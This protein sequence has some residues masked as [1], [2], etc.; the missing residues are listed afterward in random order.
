MD[1]T[2]AQQ[3]HPLADRYRLAVIYVFGSRAGEIAS[4][5][6][7]K[8]A[9]VVALQ[10]DVDVG[11]QPEKGERLSSEDRV[12]LTLALEDLFGARRVDLVVLPE[13]DAF[14]ALDIIRGE[15]LFCRDFDQQAEDELY[16]LRRAGDLSY[17]QRERIQMVLNEGGR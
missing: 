17:F 1:L 10:S 4:R 6:E 3:L 5:L 15:I 12:E 2:A 14:L 7:G 8:E 13:A 9:P 11:V 16:V